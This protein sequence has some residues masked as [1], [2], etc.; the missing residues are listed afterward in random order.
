M[1]KIDGIPSP[2]ELILSGSRAVYES[3][4]G[5]LFES[6]KQIAWD[7]DLGPIEVQTP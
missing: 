5:A 7:G 2:K 3:P 1:S 4:A 6:R